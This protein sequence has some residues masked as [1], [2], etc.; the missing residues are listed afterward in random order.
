MPPPSCRTTRTANQ[1][2]K[3]KNQKS[4]AILSPSQIPPALTRLAAP[5]GTDRYRAGKSL[6]ATAER[7]PDRLYPHFAALVA[8]L[9]SPSNIIRWNATRI[10]SFLAPVDT[11]N[12]LD[13]LLD[14]LLTPIQQHHMISAA[15]AILDT[16]RIAL[17]KPYLL[18]RILPE[19]L[20]VESATYETPECRNV[21]IAHTLDALKLLWPTV[22]NDPAVQSFIRRQTTNPRHSA[23]KRA[24]L[25]LA[26]K[27]ARH[28][29]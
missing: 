17:A 11:E 27:T 29:A 22:R 24:Q 7:H 18:P 28:V 4:P 21:C 14:R 8:L 15:N 25:L 13:Q 16:A 1:K 19:I 23:A 2:S 5:T 6:I 26:R 9:D 20:S 12:K 10:L 3:L